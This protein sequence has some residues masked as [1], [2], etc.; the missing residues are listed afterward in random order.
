MYSPSI[1]TLAF[2]V[3]DKV[4]VISKHNKD[5]QHIWESR[6]ESDFSVVED[7][8][9]NTLGRGSQIILH[10]K[11]DAE[12]FLSESKLEEVIRRYSEFINFPIYLQTNKTVT[13]EIEEEVSIEMYTEL[14]RRSFLSSPLTSVG[15]QRREKS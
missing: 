4:T 5:K 3:S 2:L 10:L 12:D 9:G 11:D 7:P 13:E 8:R 15:K 1:Q 6:A 14:C